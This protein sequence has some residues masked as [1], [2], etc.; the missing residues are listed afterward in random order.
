MQTGKNEK[1]TFLSLFPALCLCLGLVF[2]IFVVIASCSEPFSE[3]APYE[4][5]IGTA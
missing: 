3:R 4:T 5:Q 1:H 2:S